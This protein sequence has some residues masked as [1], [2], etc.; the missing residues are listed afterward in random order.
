MNPPPGLNPQFAAIFFRALLSATFV[1]VTSFLASWSQT[2]DVKSLVISTLTP[3]LGVLGT[4]FAAEGW[5]DSRI[6]NA[7][8]KP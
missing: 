3:T 8:P 7:P 6:A 4:R 1:A 2:S 5:I